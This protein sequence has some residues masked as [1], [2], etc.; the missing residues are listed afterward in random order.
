M[1]GGRD[2]LMRARLDAASLEAWIEA[3]WLVP[4]RAGPERVFSELDLA[5]AWLIRD[6]RDGM[7]VNDEGVAVAL[8]L[9]DQVHGLRQALRRLGSALHA[10]PD[11]LRRE[12]LAQLQGAAGEAPPAYPAGGAPSGVG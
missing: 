8:G 11:P 4:Q 7:G 10:L 5:R 3:G 9:L 2:F 1:L 12:I 6:M